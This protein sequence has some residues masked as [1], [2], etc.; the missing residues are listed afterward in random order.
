MFLYYKEKK[1]Y[2]QLIDKLI[3]LIRL[4]KHD[5]NND[6]QLIYGYAQLSKPQKIIDYINCCKE[7]YNFISNLKM[8]GD[9]RL[10]DCLLDMYFLAQ[11]NRVSISLE[12]IEEM[13]KGKLDKK[14]YEEIKSRVQQIINNKELDEE[15]RIIVTIDKGNIGIREE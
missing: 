5:L 13:Y 9:V 11:K 3:F 6:F 10:L 4:V 1:F 12:I 14:V 15:K 2:R 7:N 8:V